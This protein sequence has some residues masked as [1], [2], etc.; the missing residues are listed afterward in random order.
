MM[1]YPVQ[2]GPAH[3]ETVAVLV[4][5]AMRE[6]DSPAARSLLE[7]GLRVD[8]FPLT[9]APGRGLYIASGRRPGLTRIYHGTEW[10]GGRWG[11]VLAQV[12]ALIAGREFRAAVIRQRVRFSGEND[13][14]QAVWLAPELLPGHGQDVGEEGEVSR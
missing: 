5:R 3:T 2:L 11:S 6:P 1:A 12:R 13:R 9:K 7:L 8:G 10:Q 4:A 14:A